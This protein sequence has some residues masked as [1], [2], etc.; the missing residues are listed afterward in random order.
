[1]KFRKYGGNK[2]NLRDY[3]YD[4]YL[5]TVY[6]ALRTLTDDEKDCVLSNLKPHDLFALITTDEKEKVVDFINGLRK[7]LLTNLRYHNA[8]CKVLGVEPIKE[9]SIIEQYEELDTDG[10]FD[11]ALALMNE[12]SFQ[13]DCSQI[14][15]DD[16][17]RIAKSDPV[18]GALNK[19]L[20][21]GGYFERVLERGIGCDHK[22][23]VEK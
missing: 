3:T 17:K 14:L 22:Y 7:L 5:E 4:E 23:I 9:Q 10:K 12:P 21:I 2:N 11:T 8:L 20:N 19:V 13:K 18:I 15:I 6:G 1:M 16:C